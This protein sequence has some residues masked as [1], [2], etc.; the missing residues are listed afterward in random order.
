MTRADK[1]ADFIHSLVD[2]ISNHL[3][4]LYTRLYIHLALAFQLRSANSIILS[5]CEMLCCTDLK[6]KLSYD[7]KDKPDHNDLSQSC[8]YRTAKLNVCQ[9]IRHTYLELAVSSS[10]GPS[11]RDTLSVTYTSLSLVSSSSSLL[12]T[13]LSDCRW[14]LSL[15]FLLRCR[16]SVIYV[17]SQ[18]YHKIHAENSTLFY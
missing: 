2:V 17:F 15:R 3:F 12:N 7:S 1:E 8:M 4:N 16:F 13:Q 11:S 6:W 18:I 14:P 9:L 10:S 5:L